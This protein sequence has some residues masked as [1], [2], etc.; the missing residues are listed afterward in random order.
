LTYQY[1]GG[2]NA[3]SARALA[4]QPAT[5]QIYVA[6]L[7]TSTNF[8]G[9]DRGAQP[10]PQG[11]TDGFVARLSADLTQILGATYLGGSED[12]YANALAVSSGGDVYVAG[13]TFS[14]NFPNVV[15]GAQPNFGGNGD[16][17]V[18]RLN[19]DLTRIF[20][21]TY[22]GGSGSDWVWPGALILHPATGQVYVA[23]G[24]TSAN[25]PAT[26][27]GA[28]A[29]SGGDQDA[30][31]ARLQPDLTAI[32]Q[33]TYL[34]GSADDYVR[35]IAL[36]AGGDIYVAGETFSYSDLPGRAGGAQP[37]FGGGFS[38]AFVARL[39]AD[40]TRLVQPTYLGG[41]DYDWANAL[42]VHPGSGEV[43]VAG[44]TRS[45]DFPKT[46]GGAQASRRGNSDAFVARLTADL[47]G[48]TITVNGCGDA[49]AGNGRCDLAE[50]TQAAVSATAVDACP[51]GSGTMDTVVVP[52]GTYTLTRP[53][54]AFSNRRG[55]L[56]LWGA[57]AANTV[58]RWTSSGRLWSIGYGATYAPVEINGLAFD[59]GGTGSGI[60]ACCGLI[61]QNSEFRNFRADFGAALYLPATGAKVLN[62]VFRNNRATKSGGA[63]DGSFLTILYN[64]LFENN[65]AGENGGAYAGY[66]SE[67]SIAGSV[68]RNNR[69]GA[70][71]GAVYIESG[72]VHFTGTT[73]EYNQANVAGGAVFGRENISYPTFRD[74]TLS[75]NSAPDGGAVVGAEVWALNT[76]FSAN[77]GTSP[78]AG[79]AI[80]LRPGGT[81]ELAFVTFADNAGPTAINV[82]GTASGTV[83][84]KNVM[85]ADPNADECGRAGSLTI[86]AAGVV[87]ADDASCGSGSGFLVDP[88]VRSP[89]GS[90]AD[91]GGPTRTHA[92][93][94][95]SIAVDAATDCT[96]VNNQRVATDQRVGGPAAGAE[97]RCGGL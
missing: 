92:L 30:L 20:R 39:N 37:F 84:L 42:L 66:P 49:V 96:D 36:S 1:L 79:S 85:L 53:L 61:V 80:S 18:A 59:G 82:S 23:G 5:G 43:Y 19:A 58:I 29:G 64:S 75:G 51:A 34:G 68:F 74:S 26:A 60:V 63:I 93:L 76:T 50:A 11:N 86:Q 32:L 6:G 24:T 12:D 57:G 87:V 94:A 13:E 65:E 44:G 77:R 9:T 54:P 52:A 95:G 41:S 56:L 62:S 71:G 72:Y 10:S 45:A 89:L 69:A 3:D 35:G 2:T 4:I 83:K 27:G 78:T 31:V 25:L 40:L 22:P 97:M 81:A 16:A 21:S 14:Q 70:Y 73:L 17:F 8:P 33:T 28:Q 48:S 90:L 15:G 46:A 91:N 88:N 38:D 67:S 7:T 47:A 55:G